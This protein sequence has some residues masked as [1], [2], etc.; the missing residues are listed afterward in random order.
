MS[1][2]EGPTTEFLEDA[3]N[4]LEKNF[5]FLFAFWFQCMFGARTCNP[6]KSFS[7]QNASQLV[8][9]FK[10]S[11]VVV[12]SSFSQNCNVHISSIHINATQC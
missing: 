1:N 12:S 7:Q 6:C 9:F 8:T 4:L 5:T 10:K 11:V 3:S 2:P